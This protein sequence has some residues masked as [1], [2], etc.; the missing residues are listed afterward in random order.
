MQLATTAALSA[1]YY[2]V[3]SVKVATGEPPTS[4]LAV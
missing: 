2:E 1:R 4:N 3:Q